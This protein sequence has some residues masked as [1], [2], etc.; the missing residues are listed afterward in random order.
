MLLHEEFWIDYL[1]PCKHGYFL[2][3]DQEAQVESQLCVLVVI[4]GESK[5]IWKE[6]KPMG[7]PPVIDYWVK[8]DIQQ[9]DCCITVLL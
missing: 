1:S 5:H 2:T 3:E 4:A 9:H 8:K 7:F 6:L